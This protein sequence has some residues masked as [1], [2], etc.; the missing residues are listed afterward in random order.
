MSC[1]FSS[2]A[3]MMLNADFAAVETDPDVASIMHAWILMRC[4]DHEE[5]FGNNK[6]FHQ[7]FRFNM[8]WAGTCKEDQPNL[9]KKA[10]A[11]IKLKVFEARTKP[12]EGEIWR[13]SVL[14][15]EQGKMLRAVFLWIQTETPPEQGHLRRKAC[16]DVTII[17]KAE[18]E[19]CARIDVYSTSHSGFQKALDKMDT[20]SRMTRSMK[21][22]P[23]TD[24]PAS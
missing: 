6:P 15:H 9:L 13:C 3:D 17:Q 23:N 24:L 2:G 8:N 22:L 11:N 20:S 16:M 14:Q 21:N 1:G 19:A 10:L 7:L 18:G 4:C 12:H 5:M